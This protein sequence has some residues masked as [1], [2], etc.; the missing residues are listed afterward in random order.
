MKEAYRCIHLEDAVVVKS[1]LDS[2]GI[3][4]RLLSGDLLDMHPLFPKS[5]EGVRIVVADEDADDA[6]AIVEDF[7]THRGD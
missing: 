5:A 4:A 6:R 2:A 3:D 1:L 7:K